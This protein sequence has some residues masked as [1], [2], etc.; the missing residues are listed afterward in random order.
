MNQPPSETESESPSQSQKHLNEITVLLAED[1]EY[2][3]ERLARILQRRIGKL[4]TAKN[5]QEGLELFREHQPDIIITDIRMPLMDGLEM[6]Q[7]IKKLSPETPV[8]ITTAH[9]DEEF[10]LRAIDI[11]IDKYLKKPVNRTDL[12]RVLVEVS[13]SIL[14]QK[15]IESKNK[16]IRLIL[17]NSPDFVMLCDGWEINYLNRSFLTFLGCEDFQEFKERF[18]SLHSFIVPDPDTTLVETDL[19]EFVFSLSRPIQQDF[20]VKLKNGAQESGEAK[21]FLIHVNSIP[22]NTENLITLSDVTEI[23]KEKQ[24]YRELSIRDPL[25][26][27]FNRKKFSEEIIREVDRAQRYNRPLS[28]IMFDIDFFKNVNDT[29][30]HQ[31][32]DTVLIQITEIISARIRK[33]DL[34]ARYGGEEFIII[35]PETP[36]DQAM[37]IAEKLRMT[38]EEYDFKEA[39]KITCSFGTSNLEQDE[40]VHDLIRRADQALYQAKN[41]GRNNVKASAAINPTEKNG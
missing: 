26:G 15:E 2:L 29:Y 14:Q 31:V 17:D 18:G 24:H 33:T 34:L 20:L 6:A 23:E 3:R 37:E 40:V 36:L 28:L 19:C 16:F 1:E 7:E 9:N 4:I 41:S 27:A 21:T 30:G 8:V 39:G 11:G 32:G 10:F 35:A 38:V 22:Y 5:G 13:R 12:L 25:T